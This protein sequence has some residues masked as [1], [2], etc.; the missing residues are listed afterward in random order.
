M[1]IREIYYGSDSLVCYLVVESLSE[2][3]NPSKP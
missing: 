2:L 1:Q 3:F